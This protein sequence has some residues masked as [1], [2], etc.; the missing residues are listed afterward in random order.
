ME[1]APEVPERPLLA[2]QDRTEAELPIA[3]EAEVEATLAEPPR[4]IAT[5]KLHFLHLEHPCGLC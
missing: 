5:G 4:W 1:N 2:L 3:V